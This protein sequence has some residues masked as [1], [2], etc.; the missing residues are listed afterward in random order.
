MRR[1]RVTVTV[2]AMV[3]AASCKG[4]RKASP[5]GPDAA[6]SAAGAAPAAVPAAPPPLGKGAVPPAN[7]E[8]EQVTLT[9]GEAT[10]GLQAPKG[11]RVFARENTTR[12]FMSAYFQ[13]DIGAGDAD[14][15]GRRAVLEAE[16]A[17]IDAQPDL[18]VWHKETEPGHHF[19]ASVT[20]GGNSYHCADAAGPV[21]DA[22]SIKM[23]VEACRSLA[24]L[25]RQP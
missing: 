5:S 20:P 17:I 13:M 22:A 11:A 23:M 1:Y 3:I 6:P 10:L 4:Q 14:I 18:L 12:V 7:V 24:P 19:V 2:V 9:L 15:A 8:L 25:T 21:F 16:H